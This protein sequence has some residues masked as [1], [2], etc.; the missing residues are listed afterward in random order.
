MWR[1][2]DFKDKIPTDKSTD[3]TAPI[4]KTQEQLQKI[5]QQW[6]Q[7]QRN[8]CCEIVSSAHE[9]EAKL[10]KYKQYGWINKICIIRT[11]VPMALWIK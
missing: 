8:I 1:V 2:S 11:L 7:D 10:I 6:L 5:E 4:C 9:K 3:N